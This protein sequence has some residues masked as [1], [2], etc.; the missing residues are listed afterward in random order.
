MAARFTAVTP[1]F[2]DYLLAYKIVGNLNSSTEE[3][4]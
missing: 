2:S 4:N 3:R 1:T